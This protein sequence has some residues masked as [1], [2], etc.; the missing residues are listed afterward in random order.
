LREDPAESGPEQDRTI[1]GGTPADLAAFLTASGEALLGFD[2]LACCR[3]ANAPAANLLNRAPEELLG[4]P[5]AVVLPETVY[6][7]LHRNVRRSL[8]EGVATRFETFLAVGDL[9]LEARCWPDGKGGVL[10]HGRDVS[11]RRGLEDSLRQGEE[12]WQ[13]ALQRG[14]DGVWEWDLRTR[15]A[16]FSER[17]RALFLAPGEGI[18]PEIEAWN[19]RI[20]P[21]DAA[22]V[23]EAVMNHLEAETPLFVCEY[24]LRRGDG[25]AWVSDRGVALRDEHGE[26][27]RVVGATADVTEHRALEE[28]L[29]QSRLFAEQSAGLLPDILYIWDVRE[30]RVRFSNRKISQQLGYAP[31]EWASF[32]PRPF[33]T[34]VHPDDL[35]N[36]NRMYSRAVTQA[37]N[38]TAGVELRLRRR[39]GSWEW[40]FTRETV[41]SRDD[42]G[43]PTQVMGVIQRVHARKTAEL[44]LRRSEERLHLA[45]DAAQDGL[46][47]WNLV[48]DRCE[49]NARYLEMVGLTSEEFVGTVAWWQT[50]CHPEDAGR[51]EA[52]MREHIEGR[53][54]RFECEYR[55]RRRDGSEA[56]VLARGR[57]VERDATGDPVRVVG[58]NTDITAR[59]RMEQ[60]LRESRD[61]A[62]RITRMTPDLLFIYDFTKH[63]NVFVSPSVREILG[64]APEEIAAMGTALAETLFHPDDIEGDDRKLE[65]LAAAGESGVVETLYR[66]RHKSGEW[67]WLHSREMTFTT[68][69][70]GV[71]T[72][73]LAVARDITD[74]KRL[75]RERE[76]LLAEA[77]EKAEQDPLTELLNYRAF[78]E[79]LNRL[80]ERATAENPL[81]VAVLDVDNFK[82]FNEAFGHT[83]GDH[84]LENIARTLRAALPP[85]AQLARLG[86]DEFAALL[87]NTPRAVAERLFWH[88]L[89]HRLGYRPAGAEGDVPLS[90]SCGVALYPTEADTPM[91]AVLLADSRLMES[92]RGGQ[93]GL[94]TVRQQIAEA[95][96]GFPLLDA[97]VM[98]VDVKDRYTRRHS[99][100]VLLY[101]LLMAQDLGWSETDRSLLQVAALLHD[102]GKIGVPDRILRLPTRLTD[103]EYRQVRQHAPLGAALVGSVLGL[104]P[105]TAAVRHHHEAWDGRGYPDGISGE[106]IPIMARLLAV[107][108]AFSALTTDR[109][110]R[111]GLDRRN[112]LAVLQSG[113]GTQWDPE[114]VASLERIMSGKKQ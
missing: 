103:D 91:G 22:R 72:Q 98:A 3:Y 80:G 95:M 5:L 45:L 25:Y 50:A 86:G 70:D 76:E 21:D 48:T 32:G 99:E 82:F 75:E 62:D 10:L 20:H 57:V 36:L 106:A 27:Y 58:T 81:C 7:V 83:E 114:C 52:A 26:P 38:E 11:E 73:V 2:A 63:R 85:G 79:R 93:E 104:D 59:R 1:V 94:N 4:Q 33:E 41:F 23:V 54:P 110:Y 42:A 61:F 105:V 101:S 113:A 49:V 111:K 64:Y 108:D 55:L 87:P 65:L 39:D 14:S 19:A 67:R 12:R 77:I 46:W 24:R 60:E 17:W 71:P 6:G 69:A 47:D 68:D 78:H 56:W 89:P 16:F 96:A 74:Y 28:S 112:A 90:I 34:V 43:F 88:H 37:D 66:L 30:D 18:E 102:V 84:V 29:R 53:A 40:Y 35:P 9:W 107:A 97:L 44:E 100:D 13:F 31:E 15:A 51:V 92:K 109:P 8:T